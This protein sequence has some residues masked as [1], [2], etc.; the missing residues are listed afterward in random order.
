MPYLMTPGLVEIIFDLVVDRVKM[1]LAEATTI[2][3]ER[4][5]NE[6]INELVAFDCIAADDGAGVGA[7]ATGGVGAAA[8][9]VLVLLLVVL[10]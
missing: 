8:A 1:V 10:V 9:V 2:K 3:K 4:V 5:P 7:A 6:V